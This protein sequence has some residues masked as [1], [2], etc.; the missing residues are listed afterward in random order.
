MLATTHKL[1]PLAVLHKHEAAV[2]HG[3]DS[4][5]VRYSR[6]LLD[7]PQIRHA[8][9]Y[10]ALFTHWPGRLSSISAVERDYNRL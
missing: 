8:F 9:L 7:E 10:Y 2:L 4:L 6:N 3:L 1:I 5:P